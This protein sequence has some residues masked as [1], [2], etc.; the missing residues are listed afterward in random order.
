MNSKPYKILI[1]DDDPMDVESFR[2]V[3]K[4]EPYDILSAS[5]GVNGLRI[6]DA[7]KP[8]LVILDLKMS[9]M[10]GFDFLNHLHENLKDTHSVI[11]LTGNCS[12]AD[13][14][15][16]FTL[17]ISGFLRK[18]FNVHELKGLL[19]NSVKL[20]LSLIEQRKAKDDLHKAYDDLEKRVDSRTAELKTAN[21]KLKNEIEERK[22]VEKELFRSKQL[23][24]YA[25]KA[26]SDIIF[27]WDI[28]NDEVNWFGNIDAILGYPQNTIPRSLYGILNYVHPHDVKRLK[29]SIYQHR[30]RTKF[31]NEEY[32]IRKSDGSYRSWI[33]R[34]VAVKDSHGAPVRWIGACIDVTEF[35]EVEATLRESE[36]NF[37]LLAENASDIIWTMDLNLRQVYTSP[38]VER[39]RGF[40]P[41]EAAEHSL[42]KVLTPHSLNVALT[43]LDEHRESINQ[44]TFKPITL[45]LELYCKDGSTILAES[46]ISIIY[47]DGNP[48]RI[49][50]ISRDITDRKRIEE[51][52]KLKNSI[53][54]AQWESSIDGILIVDAN[55]EVMTF[56][57]RFI[58][59]W[60][61]PLEVIMP[62]E[63]APAIKWLSEK[64]IY[65]EDFIQQIQHLAYD[66]H[67]IR[68]GELTVDN[69]NIF[70]Y[71]LAPIFGPNRLYYGRIWSFRD[72]TDR[73]QAEAKLKTKNA[74]LEDINIQ[75]QQAIENARQMAINA[76][77]ANQA[78]SEFLANVS[79]E[80]RTP[81]NA[82]MGMTEI[83]L[84]SQ[85]SDKQRDYL[86]AIKSASSSLLRII[87]DI[88]DFSKITVG[89]MKVD[90]IPFSLR[91][92]VKET[93]AVLIHQANEKE[94][95]LHFKVNDDVYDFVR[96]DPGRLRQIL[97]NL[98]GNAIKFTERGHVTLQVK[99]EIETSKTVKIRFEVTDTGI[100][101]PVD[102]RNV[103]FKSFS[104]VDASMTRK[105]G[106]TGLGLA[107]S[108]K[109][110]EL[111]G[112]EIGVVSEEGRGS[113]FWFVF[114]MEKHFETHQAP[115]ENSAVIASKRMLV[116]ESSHT[117]R[118][119]LWA[120]LNKKIQRCDM[121]QNY[122][123]TIRK[124]VKASEGDIGYDLVIV[125]D[126]IGKKIVEIRSGTGELSDQ[127]NALLPKLKLLYVSSR[128]D[129]GE[130]ALCKKM[131]FNAYLTKP[132]TFQQV[133]NCLMAL[134]GSEEISEK[135]MITQYTWEDYKTS[136]PQPQ[137]KSFGLH[138]LLA[139]D[140]RLNQEI[141]VYFLELLGC[142]VVT[143]EDGQAAIDAY[144][145]ETFDIILMDGQMPVMDG[146]EATQEIRKLTAGGA[147][148]PIIA[149][150]AHAMPGDQE[151]FLASG[152]NGYIPKPLTLDKLEE[153]LS[154]IFN[155]NIPKRKKVAPET[156]V[157]AQLINVKKFSTSVL[158][159]VKLAETIKRIFMEDHKGV[160]ATIQDSIQSKRSEALH[161][162]AHKLKGM[163]CNIS[164][165]T[166]A[167]LAFSLEKMGE[168][169]K[170]EEAENTYKRLETEIKRL[171]PALD[172]VVAML[173]E[174][175]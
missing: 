148:I 82:I 11:V 171:T 10:D 164:A 52:L 151:R 78:K 93:M 145:K 76:E 128:P 142:T 138:I 159:N 15:R 124:I 27:E 62:N 65:P 135:E 115:I 154:H 112:G 25:A 158:G 47:K 16:C 102:K 40:T 141:T 91:T 99:Q 9:G 46:E 89:E 90:I 105:Y 28:R 37:R 67:T 168:E 96:L 33:M 69:A 44:G 94:L 146:I 167:D 130:A 29:H 32:R 127:L 70:D 143:V 153:S 2:L 39:V 49:M 66:E 12:D 98:V 81:M 110:V 21:E 77:N 114:E 156:G 169:S 163:L 63:A 101:I 57:H 26:V 166:A 116:S 55:G 152:M 144:K 38:S 58:E 111:L 155:Q 42:D 73:K 54:S 147:D 5:D 14:E 48:D 119:M 3:L 60:D 23:F 51:E 79:H 109:L 97:I 139:E 122:D 136:A 140:N 108:K 75:L 173:H 174:K 22:H 41:E 31:P 56:N 71:Y 104:Q 88:L 157:S 64:V 125:S 103:L 19:R 17:G 162:S 149:L 92:T 129:K 72:I 85:I 121:A 87:N 83:I 161:R 126:T 80:I 30:Y 86:N 100:G 84:S 172:D 120:Y 133:E 117:E 160:M 43:A 59:M 20:R 6:Y 35:R 106:G 95:E 50:G 123:E 107:I 137:K 68:H 18:P 13:I 45:E 4:D 8:L 7:H 132:F 113:Q 1:I 131:G 53:L 118:E 175:G 170:L 34:G 36:E 134:F 74:E 24:S 150:T 165:E 61:I